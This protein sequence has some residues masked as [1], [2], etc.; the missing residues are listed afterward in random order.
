MKDFTDED[1]EY[2]HA[3]EIVDLIDDMLNGLIEDDDG[4]GIDFDFA[5]DTL[6]GIKATIKRTGRVTTGQE[7]AVNNIKNGAMH[8]S[9]RHDVDDSYGDY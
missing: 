6:E 9:H 4:D 5:S 3:D 1:D 2:T 8:R 7:E